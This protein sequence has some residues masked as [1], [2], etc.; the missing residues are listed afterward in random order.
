MSSAFD[1]SRRRRASNTINRLQL[2]VKIYLWQ[3]NVERKSS[4]SF[5]AFWRW[6]FGKNLPV[7]LH[8]WQ[9][10]VDGVSERGGAD[11]RRGQGQGANLLLL[12]CY[13]PV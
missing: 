9:E 10:N 3:E 4:T 6:L 11:G 12:L 13:S 5:G 1:G 7:S 8:L 2:R